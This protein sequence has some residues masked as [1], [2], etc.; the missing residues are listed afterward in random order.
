MLVS[1][2]VLT[3]IMTFFWSIL[4]S[5][6]SVTSSEE[7]RM[8]SLEEARRGFRF[9]ELDWNAR[10]AFSPQAIRHRETEGNDEVGWIG[11]VRGYAGNRLPLASVAYRLAYDDQDTRAQLERAALGYQYGSDD[12]TQPHL[13]VDAD[14]PEPADADFE[15]IAED[16]FR[17]E[18]GYLQYDPDLG[19]VSYVSE[20]NG[21]LD[22]L[23]AMIVTVASVRLPDLES[24]SIDAEAAH[25]AL[26]E[27]FPDLDGAS[28]P[29]RL[30][31]SLAE[32]A[33]E[34]VET[35]GLPWPAAQ[36]I[37]VFERTYV[38]DPISTPAEESQP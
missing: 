12:S 29:Y 4:Q 5:V 27:M 26:V 19:Q 37:R 15:V 24:L 13:Y 3:I 18:V 20:P 6:S 11:Y 34:V 2:A 31:R 7:T 33:A 38:F 14:I 32:D 25:Q 23:K 1:I 36:S 22:N 35:A 30:W 28:S 21:D 16:L 10:V 8:S 17:F 9:F